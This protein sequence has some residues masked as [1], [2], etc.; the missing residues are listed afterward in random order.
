[1]ALTAAAMSNVR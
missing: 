1:M